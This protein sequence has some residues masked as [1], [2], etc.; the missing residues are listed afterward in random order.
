M[1]THFVAA[2]HND[3][4]VW[5]KWSPSVA[6]KIIADL[7]ANVRFLSPGCYR[8]VGLLLRLR[9]FEAVCNRTIEAAIGAIARA[10]PLGRNG[11][12]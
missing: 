10:V 2:P 11:V 12:C 1:L 6:Q 5:H 8:I 4:S 7:S 3:Y 9:L